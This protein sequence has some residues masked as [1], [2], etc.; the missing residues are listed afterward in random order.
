M[1][2]RPTPPTMPAPTRIKTYSKE[3]DNV[4]KSGARNEKTSGNFSRLWGEKV[5]L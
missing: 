1:I 2:M 3:G 4:G 5:E